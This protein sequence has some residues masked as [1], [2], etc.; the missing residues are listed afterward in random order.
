MWK[1]PRPKIMISVTGECKDFFWL[2]Y[3][4]GDQILLL[5]PLMGVVMYWSMCACKVRR[6]KYYVGADIRSGMCGLHMLTKTQSLKPYHRHT[7]RH[8]HTHKHKHI[9][10]HTH[11][12]TYTLTRTRTRTHTH[13][14]THTHIYI[15]TNTHIH[16]HNLTCTHTHIHT[17]THAHT[18]TYTHT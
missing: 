7:H 1:L 16:T 10:T 17:H 5:V 14:H 11:A 8:R 13:T 4:S 9:H 15:Q 18:H 3:N 2:M 6:V 12:H